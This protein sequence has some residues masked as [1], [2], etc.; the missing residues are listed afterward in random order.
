MK[1]SVFAASNLYFDDPTLKVGEEVSLRIF[2]SEPENV[3]EGKGTLQFDTSMLEFVSGTNAMA[4]EGTISLEGSKNGEG[5]L[6]YYLVLKALKAG[7]TTITPIDFTASNNGAS[8]AVELGNSTVTIEPGAN[9]ETEIA[10]T[11]A[12]L[13]A[14][15]EG[16]SVEVG[17]VSYTLV[18]EFEESQVPEGFVATDV[19]Y[20]DAQVKG[21]KQEAGSVE[22]LYLMSSAG[23]GSFFVYDSEDASFS[24]FEQIFLRSDFY[25]I[26]LD[27]EAKGLP[28]YYKETKMT[29]NGKDF[30]AWQNTKSPDFFAVSA[31]SST[32]EKGV[33]SYD[34]VGGTYQ[35]FISVKTEEGSSSGKLLSL[36][37]QYEDLLPF[38]FAGIALLLLV[39]FI[40]MLVFGIKLRRRNLEL[41]EVYDEYGIDDNEDMTESTDSSKSKRQQYEEGEFDEEDDSEDI[42]SLDEEFE[43]EEFDDGELDDE[44]FDETAELLFD[45]D[46]FIESED[47]DENFELNLDD[48]EEDEVQS[49]LRK[50][51]QSSRKVFDT[52]F[53]DLD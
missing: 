52:D 2:V 24:P 50:K 13:V 39:F 20:K 26:L 3:T 23:E 46:D 45:E 48:V 11:T 4:S 18:Q 22:L 15:T 21:A 34:S 19:T 40:L 10:T 31:A 49:Q 47:I 51:D 53:I 30:P 12:A 36:L 8:V 27:E 28:S 9:G 7:K 32:G 25:I 6:E 38:V 29:I 37:E 35:R 17:G 16:Q 41:D 42:L 14:A 5:K 44:D 43:D 1:I 33:Y